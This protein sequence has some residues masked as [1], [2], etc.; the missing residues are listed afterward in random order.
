MDESKSYKDS[1]CFSLFLQR[2]GLKSQQI[3]NTAT[4]G[5]NLLDVHKLDQ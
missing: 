5:V 2:K 1:K 3:F 4:I